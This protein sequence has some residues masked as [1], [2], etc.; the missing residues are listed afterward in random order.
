MQIKSSSSYTAPVSGLSVPDMEKEYNLEGQPAQ[1]IAEYFAHQVRYGSTFWNMPEHLTNQFGDAMIGAS[2]FAGNIRPRSVY[3]FHLIMENYA[4]YLGE[5]VNTDFSFMS[6]SATGESLTV[7]MRPSQKGFSVVN[8]LVGTYAR[9][10]RNAKPHCRPISRAALSRMEVRLN[11]AEFAEALR[12]ELI[13]L[14]DSGV[15]IGEEEILGAS[16]EESLEQVLDRSPKDKMQIL[17]NELVDIVTETNNLTE[18]AIA[19]FKDMSIAR[20]TGFHSRIENGRLVMDRLLPYQLIFDPTFDCDFNSRG[21]YKGIIEWLT[22]EEIAAR[23][24]SGFTKED[25]KILRD[26]H[27]GVNGNWDNFLNDNAS[28][29]YN[30]LSTDKKRYT[31]ITMYFE[32]FRDMGI[33]M[34]EDGSSYEYRHVRNIKENEIQKVEQGDF[35]KPVMFQATLVANRFLYNYGESAHVAY[36]PGDNLQP[37]FPITMLLP[38]M[39]RG[40]VKSVID[41]TK[42]YISQYEAYK[43]VIAKKAARAHGKVPVLNAAFFGNK[44]ASGIIKDIVTQGFVIANF[45]G[46]EWLDPTTNKRII[47]VMDFTM[48]SDIQSLM[49]LAEAEDRLI[50]SVYNTTPI[51]TG[52]QQTYVGSSTQRDSIAQAT[53]GTGNDVEKHATFL[54]QSLHVAVNMLKNYYG[55]DEGKAFAERNLSMAS[56]RF[57]K[58]TMDLNIEH[59]GVYVTFMD[60]L[61]AQERG[62]I[63]QMA[64]T[65]LPSGV[66]PEVLN[67]LVDMAKAP[68]ATELRNKIS[69]LASRVK[70]QREQA[71]QDQAEQAAMQQQLKNQGPQGVEQIKTQGANQRMEM[72]QAG[73]SER[74]GFKETMQAQA[75][76]AQPQQPQV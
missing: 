76:G 72:Q 52:T 64:Q 39:T 3:P 4:V 50:D 24:Y 71:A 60:N 62:A 11:M 57:L 2:N 9:A 63:V 6:R 41:R 46:G 69:A 74:T 51:V 53:V 18:N 26:G 66:D 14:A 16:R 34:K 37:L 32:G 15:T 22:A 36:N 42:D 45:S 27:T 40:K 70:K 12:E 38:N 61:D 21:K 73:E 49:A 23:N 54:A 56:Y 59:L 33:K 55:S 48:D 10:I 65:L 29:N 75:K 20:Y 19:S 8:F 13:E 1:A 17:G 30:W 67:I 5:Q 47:D 28:I 43:Y 68:T 35:F 25:F 7:P 31:V 44:K 58:E